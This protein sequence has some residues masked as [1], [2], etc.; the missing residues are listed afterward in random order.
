MEKFDSS[1]FHSNL[2]EEFRKLDDIL[3]SFQNRFCDE[4]FLCIRTQFPDLVLTEE[5][6]ELILT[7]AN[8]IFNTA[9]SVQDK[10]KNYIDIRLAEE[11]SVM[12]KVVDKLSEEKE[13]WG[14][15][16]KL[17][18]RAK[19]LMVGYNPSLMDLSADGFRLLEKYSLMYNIFFLDSFTTIAQSQE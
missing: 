1:N 8:Q 13:N 5:L 3:E 4:V 2:V 9:E 16:Q 11:V 15:G 19:E 14:L 7:Y 6:D 12:N 17:H 18:Q 10:D